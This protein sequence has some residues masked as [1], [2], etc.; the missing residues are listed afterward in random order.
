MARRGPKARIRPGHLVE[1][2]DTRSEHR[3][4]GVPR[5]HRKYINGVTVSET[6]A[7]MIRRWRKGQIRGVTESSAHALL[8]R[9][10]INPR[11]FTT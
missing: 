3:V 10:N 2:L 7:R 6:D 4:D 9:H 1:F 11:E 8:R 5:R